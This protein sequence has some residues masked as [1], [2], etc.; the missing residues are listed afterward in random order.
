MKDLVVFQLQ[1][2]RSQIHANRMCKMI[3]LDR[4]SDEDDL[5][6]GGSNAAVTEER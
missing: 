1:S 4:S 5:M 6:A 3:K 2:G